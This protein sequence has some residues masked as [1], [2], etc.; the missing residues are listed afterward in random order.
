MTFTPSLPTSRTSIAVD[1]AAEDAC[2]I[3]ERLRAYISWLRD[4]HIWESTRGGGE[5]HG[6]ASEE[7]SERVASNRLHASPCVSSAFLGEVS[8]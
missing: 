5:T 4:F 6:V 3:G 8:A 1:M 7:I 2:A